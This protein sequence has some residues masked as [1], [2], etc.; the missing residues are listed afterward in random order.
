MVESLDDPYSDFMTKDEAG[1]F[2]QS[3]SS[4]FEGIGAEIQQKDNQIVIVSPIKGAPAEKAG[5]KAGDIILKVNGKS[6]HGMSS[7]NA[8]L[9]IR[10]KKGTTVHLSIQRPGVEK[11]MEIELASISLSLSTF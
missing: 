1:N 10:G 4:S 2:H 11:T 9:L 8:V 5:L 3:L 7:S 6:L